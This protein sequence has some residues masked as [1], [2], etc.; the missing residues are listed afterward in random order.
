[1]SQKLTSKDRFEIAVQVS[2][3]LIP[4]V[5]SSISTA[6]FSTKPEKRFKRIKSF[7]EEF[8]IQINNL[9]STICSFDKHDE[10]SLIAI[11]ER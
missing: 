8:L 7:Y 1:M 5:G 11:I 10:D 3:Q 9:E 6:Y 4:S 2:L